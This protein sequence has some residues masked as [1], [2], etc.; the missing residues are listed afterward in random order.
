MRVEIDLDLFAI[1]YIGLPGGA[2]LLASE[3][4]SELERRSHLWLDYGGLFSDLT[5]LDKKSAA[6]R[7]G[8][9]EVV[10]LSARSVLLIGPEDPDLKLRLEKEITLDDTEPVL[11]YTVRAMTS[12]AEPYQVSIR[13]TAQVPVGRTVQMGPQD[14]AAFRL[15]G[16]DTLDEVAV[17]E[18]EGWL[19]PIPPRTLKAPVAIA[20][21]GIKTSV[22]HGPVSWQRAWAG[23]SPESASAEELPEIECSMDPASKKYSWSITSPPRRLDKGHPLEFKEIWTLRKEEERP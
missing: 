5:P 8:P 20:A 18:G 22:H 12:R 9:A 10:Y 23:P 3:Y 6:L 14:S 15:V 17:A 4:V 13:N 19:V 16:V 2:N 7:R 21:P 11:H 1:R